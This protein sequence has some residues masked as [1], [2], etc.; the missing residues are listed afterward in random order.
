[1]AGGIG[2]LGRSPSGVQGLCSWWDR[3]RSP[4]KIFY[5]FTMVNVYSGAFWDEKLVTYRVL[6]YN[7]KYAKLLIKCKD[8]KEN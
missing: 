5:I 2:G 4:R 3:E 8:N 1:M 6:N 7:T